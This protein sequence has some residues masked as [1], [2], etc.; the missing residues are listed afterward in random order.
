MVSLRSWRGCPLL[1]RLLG[2]Q[3]DENLV[4]QRP[5]FGIDALNDTPAPLGAFLE[6]HAV[7]R[8]SQ[9][10]IEPFFLPGDAEPQPKPASVENVLASVRRCLVA[11]EEAHGKIEKREALVMALVHL[12]GWLCDSAE[13]GD[14]EA[15]RELFHCACELTRSFVKCAEAGFPATTDSAKRAHEIPGFV[16]QHDKDVMQRMRNLC[17]KIGQGTKAPI[18]PAPK[19]KLGRRPTLATPQNDLAVRLYDYIEKHRIR[20]KVFPHLSKSEIKK[21]KGMGHVFDPLFL[22]MLDLPELTPATTKQWRKIGRWV[23]NRHTEDEPLWH[24]A[25]CPGGAYEKMDDRKNARRESKLWDRLAEAWE[26][27]AKM[28]GAHLERTRRKR[29]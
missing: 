13:T 18:P 3:A 12:Q 6:D 9:P 11:A 28:R 5:A 10:G 26:R 4:N 20:R 15:E 25:F 1:H 8:N 21:R 19:G 22:A 24:P 23:L 14:R 16:S 27:L 17:V 2:E 29:K 7:A